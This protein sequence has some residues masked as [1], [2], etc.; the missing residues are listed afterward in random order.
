MELFMY[1]KETTEILHSEFMAKTGDY[2]ES[3]RNLRLEKMRKPIEHTVK[4]SCK[5]I[6]K[7]FAKLQISGKLTLG[8]SDLNSWSIKFTNI[9]EERMCP[10]QNQKS[11]RRDERGSWFA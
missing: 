2:D 7:R 1:F 8:Q 6:E 4:L 3:L 5:G 10:G 9:F 11:I